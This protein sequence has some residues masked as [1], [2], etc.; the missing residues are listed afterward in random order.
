M[1]G[2]S[3]DSTFLR[4]PGNQ[5]ASGTNESFKMNLLLIPKCHQRQTVMIFCDVIACTDC[6]DLPHTHRAVLTK[7]NAKLP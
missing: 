6:C 7:D 1:G 5:L 2:P 4:Y 3:G